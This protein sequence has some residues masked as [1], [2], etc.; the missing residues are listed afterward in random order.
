M[1][2]TPAA[3]I[4]NKFKESRA[5]TDSTTLDYRSIIGQMNY[6]AMTTHPDIAFAVHQCACF[7]SDPRK[8]HYKAVKRIA[9]YLALTRDKGLTLRP[10]DPAM[11]CYVDADFAGT[12]T[13]EYSDDSSTALSRT[14][15]VI[16]FAGCPV[17]WA[18]KMQTEIAL[19][20][21]EAE[22]IALS[23]AMRDVIPVCALLN[24]LSD[25]GLIQHIG[26]SKVRCIVFEDNASCLELA[27]APKMRPRTKHINIKYHHFCSH[28]NSDQNPDG[29]IMIQHVGTKDQTTDIFTKPLTIVPFEHLRAKLMR[30]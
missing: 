10:G 20:T 14:G 23:A 30:W 13:K 25:H 11:E 18:S 19:S 27:L 16:N 12:W 2:A 28:I 9:R 15:F 3:I 6:L 24:E 8:P 29:T 7:C 5:T 4:L 21:T 1:H 22:Y 26:T 17:V